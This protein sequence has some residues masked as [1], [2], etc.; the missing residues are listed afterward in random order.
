M[1]FVHLLQTS[2]TTGKILPQEK[3]DTLMADHFATFI[4]DYDLVSIKS[5]HVDTLR[6][7]VSYNL[8]IAEHNRTDTFPKGELLA[9]DRYVLL[10]VALIVDSSIEYST[11][12]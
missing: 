9:L 4:T 3:L 11:M 7:P 2:L 1:T 8:F 5:A 6:I 10:D 12:A